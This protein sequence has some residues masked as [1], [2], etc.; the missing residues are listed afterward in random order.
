[1]S[2][3]QFF[4]QVHVYSMTSR[5][6]LVRYHALA[7][8]LSIEIWLRLAEMVWLRSFLEDLDISSPSPM[9]MHCDNQATIFINVNSTFYEH[10]KHIEID[11]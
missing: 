7:Q 11:C 4:T 9:P 10:T 1:M 2:S 5:S 6:R 3:E 8:S